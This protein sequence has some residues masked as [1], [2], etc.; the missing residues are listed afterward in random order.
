MKALRTLRAAL[1]RRESAIMLVF[2]FASGL[3]F[4]LVGMTASIWMREAGYALG[5]IG[6]IAL[7]GLFYVLKFLWAPLLDRWQLPILGALGRRRGWLLPTQ[8]V[9]ALGLLGMALAGPT[10]G[11]MFIVMLGLVAFA[12]A[13][14]DTLVDAWRIEVAPSEQRANMVAIYSLGYRLGLIIGGAG[15]LV[16]AEY[17]GWARTYVVLALLVAPIM[18]ATWW[19]PEPALSSDSGLTPHH[20]GLREFVLAPFIEFFRRFGVGT[21]L[22]LLLFVG[23][24]KLPDQMLG[25]IAG[26]FYL[27]SGFSKA[28]IASVSKLYGVWIGLLGALV[29]AVAVNALGVWR[30]L[31]LAAGLVALSNLLYLTMALH[32]GAL[33]AFL[34]TISGDNFGIGFAGTVLVTFSSG[35]TSPGFTATQFALLVALANLP[36]KLI[37]AISGFLVEHWGYAGFF[38]L[39]TVSII[40]TLLAF[41]WLYRRRLT[42]AGLAPRA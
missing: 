13:T 22:L 30:S 37:G 14:Q 35:L 31:L 26:P 21:A 25:V 12:S 36:G 19:A 1:G 8:A 10:S 4:L 17:L 2:G 34:L 11:T 9:L 5:E 28:E 42:L 6:L 20:L 33:W 38:L 24:Y 41:V 27:D 39:S 18:L 23:L 16:L 32:P 7:A 3:P 29:G 15:A 40:P